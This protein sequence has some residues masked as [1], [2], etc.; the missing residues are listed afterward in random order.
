VSPQSRAGGRS[1]ADRQ[2]ETG[3]ASLTRLTGCQDLS[4]PDGDCGS[5]RHTR[6]RGP[7]E[8]RADSTSRRTGWRRLAPR[9]GGRSGERGPL[10]RAGADGRYLDLDV[11]LDVGVGVGGVGQTV[12]DVQR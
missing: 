11:D 3:M 1:T 4:G 9:A 2:G 7:R 5:L 8:P 12:H 6:S 10:G